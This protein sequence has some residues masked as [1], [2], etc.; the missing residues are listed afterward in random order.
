MLAFCT[1]RFPANISLMQKSIK[2]TT[3]D[4]ICKKYA[5]SHPCRDYVFCETYDSH[6]RQCFKRGDCRRHT[7]QLYIHDIRLVVMSEDIAAE[8]NIT[9][10]MCEIAAWSGSGFQWLFFYPN[11]TTFNE[12]DLFRQIDDAH[13]RFA[14]CQPPPSTS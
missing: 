7:V 13:I 1:S 5:D 4:N 9:P 14:L 11:S 12:S 8:K 6:P 2:E 3:I 10:V